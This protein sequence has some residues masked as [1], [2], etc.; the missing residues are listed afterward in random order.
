MQNAVDADFNAA[1]LKVVAVAKENPQTVD[2][3]SDAVERLAECQRILAFLRLPSVISWNQAAKVR[4]EIPVR[5][6]L[7]D[8]GTT[9]EE[10]EKVKEELKAKMLAVKTRRMLIAEKMAIVPSENDSTDSCVFNQ[11]IEEGMTPQ[12][13]NNSMRPGSPMQELAK[14]NVVRPSVEPLRISLVSADHD[15]YLKPRRE[16]GKYKRELETPVRLVAQ[17]RDTKLD[18]E[19]LR[20]LITQNVLEHVLR[21]QKRIVSFL[22]SSTFTDTAWERN[23]LIDDVIPYLQEYSQHRNFE[24]KLVEMRWG[25]RK[26]ASDAHKTSEICMA[27][28]ARAQRESQ[29]Y[30]YV[31]LGC[32]KYGYRPF[33]SK[34]P[35]PIYDKLYEA[36]RHLSREAREHC[37]EIEGKKQNHQWLLDQHY[38]LGKHSRSVS[39]VCVC[40]C[41][42]PPKTSQ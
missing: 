35:K 11:G 32:Q 41:N 37:V 15:P 13:R 29:G 40:M 2:A 20:G 1:T 21:V 38:Q 25:I 33:P 14:A 31:F 9:G 5:F 3:H 12:T 39:D 42:L 8:S 4:Y 34:I 16:R 18:G 23:L 10:D 19:I 36:S 22:L 7:A 28:L 27:E 26:E 6:P 24:I 30:F 17:S